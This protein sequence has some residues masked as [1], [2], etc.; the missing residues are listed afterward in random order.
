[1]IGHGWWFETPLN[2][3]RTRLSHWMRRQLHMCPW[4]QCKEYLK[5]VWCWNF[6]VQYHCPWRGAGKGASGPLLSCTVSHFWFSFTLGNTSQTSILKGDVIPMD[7]RQYWLFSDRTVPSSQRR[8]FWIILSSQR[9]GFT[10]PFPSSPASM[11]FW[12]SDQL[13]YPTTTGVTQLKPS[14]SAAPR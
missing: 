8:N 3:S 7:V 6:F 14:P 1:M 2:K 13:I 10:D 4:K 12:G 5:Q 11:Q 9:T